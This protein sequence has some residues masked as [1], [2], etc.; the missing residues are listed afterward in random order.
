MTAWS[1]WAR[2]AFP[3]WLPKSRACRRKLP[4]LFLTN[5]A[6]KSRLDYVRRLAKFGIRVKPSDVMTASYGCAHYIAEKYGRGRKVHYIGENGLRDELEAEAEAKLV[7][8]GAEFLVMGLDRQVTYEK[9]DL[10]FC[11]LAEGA[12]FI[13]ANGDPTLPREE[14]FSLGSG[15]IA[16]ALIYASGRKPDVVIGKP[17]V[18]LVE[19]L[20]SMHRIKPRD[21]AFVGDRLDIDMRMANKAGMESV[22]VLTGV[23]KRGDVSRAPPATG[24]A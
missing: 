10:G 15:A 7:S 21:A 4:V 5:N 8:R 19:K 17:S 1:T 6:T 11:N 20:L 18:Y 22:L 14:G 23:A 24:R 16:A 12:K 3:E 13:L 9:L 2:T